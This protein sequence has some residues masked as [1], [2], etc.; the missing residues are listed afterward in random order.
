MQKPMLIDEEY[1]F[2]D[3]LILSSTNLKGIITYT[4]SKVL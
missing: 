4:Q 3:N 1:H 2:N